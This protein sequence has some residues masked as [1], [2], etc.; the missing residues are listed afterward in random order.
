VQIAK[1]FGAHVTGVQSTGA[2]DLVR[3]LGADRVIDYTKDDF[4]TASALRR[5][6]RQRLQPNAGRRPAGREA[7]GTVV[8]NGGGSPAKNVSILGM[9]GTWLTSRSSVR[10]CCSA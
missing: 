4:T 1:A 5:R 6:L 8:P 9:L 7:G 3:S 10:R 2:C